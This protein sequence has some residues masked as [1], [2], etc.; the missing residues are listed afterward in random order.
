MTTDTPSPRKWWHKQQDDR[1]DLTRLREALDTL[2]AAPRL[3]EHRR[4]QKLRAGSFTAA[5][6]TPENEAADAYRELRE[7]LKPEKPDGELGQH[8]RYLQGELSSRSR[9][10]RVAEL[11]DVIE[12]DRRR[13]AVREL[14]GDDE[15]LQALETLRDVM[16]I[17][18]GAR[19]WSNGGGSR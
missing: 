9:T 12:R 11:L 6:V 16:D 1:S 10:D 19:L 14:D 17:G 5:E 13:A 7:L 4:A 3:T 18:D 15:H 2:G 8:L